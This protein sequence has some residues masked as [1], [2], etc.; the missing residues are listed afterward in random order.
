MINDIYTNLEE[1]ISDCFKEAA[2]YAILGVKEN[3]GGPFGAAIIQKNEDKYKVICIERNTV[4][5]TKDATCHAEINAIRK[6]SN[7]L[8]KRELSDCILI[9]TSKSCPMCLSAAC[10]ANIPVIYYGSTYTDATTAGFKDNDIA[11]YIKGKNS[12]IIKEIK[13]NNLDCITPFKVWN[14]KDDKINY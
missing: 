12:E 9:T 7:L 3:V 10:W 13:V 14:E 4:I 5:T 1:C 6:A 11:E 2:N 8:N